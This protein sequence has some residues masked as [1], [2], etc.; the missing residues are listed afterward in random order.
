VD[1]ITK[2]DGFIN[3]LVGNSGISGPSLEGLKPTSTLAEIQETLWKSDID[4]FTNTYRVN[5]TAVF[6][7]VIAFLG[8]LDAGNKKG[9]VDQ[10]SQVITTSSIGGFNRMPLAGYAYGTSKAAVTHMMKQ[11]S[12]ALAP[13]GI[14]FN[15]I[16]PGGG[17]R[18]QR[19]L[20]LVLIKAVYPSEMTSELMEKKFPDGKFPKT[21]VPLERAGTVEDM[22]GTILY[23]T[24]RA[25]A[26]LNGN[27]TVTDG[28]RLSIVQSTY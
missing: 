19:Q 8:L 21:F 27:V 17:S 1:H 11:F 15:V 18:A 26:Y 23:M 3:V 5:T 6:Y 2:E 20:N 13:H 28:G 7:S 24:S 9:N 25:G 10:K 14:R 16:A 12:T 22:A 4:E